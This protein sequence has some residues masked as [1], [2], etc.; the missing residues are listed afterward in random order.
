MRFVSIL[1][2]VVDSNNDH[3]VVVVVVVLLC[4]SVQCVGDKV[5]GEITKTT[6]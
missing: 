4:L 1:V 2:V 3:T 5:E 6:G